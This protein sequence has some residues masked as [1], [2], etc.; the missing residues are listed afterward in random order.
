[1]IRSSHVPEVRMGQPAKPLKV[2]VIATVLN[3][4]ARVAELIDSLATQTRVPD[5][6]IIADGGST[7]GTTEKIR[8]A[9]EGRLKVTILNL[10]GSN[11]SEGRNAAV[12]TATGDLIA[13]T[14]AGVR[15]KRNWLELLIAPFEKRKGRLDVVSGFFESDPTTVFELAMG[16]TVLPT[17]DEINPARFLPSSR[18]VA[19]TKDA[20]RRAGG[21]PEW[22]DYCEDVVFDLALRRN[23]AVFGWAPEAVALFR[24]RPSLRS[25]WHQYFRY[26]RGDG[27]AGLWPLRHAVRYGSYA[28]ALAFLLGSRKRW[29]LLLPLAVGAL[30]HMQ[31]PYQRLLRSIRQL[32]PAEQAEAVAWVPI[33]R[34][35][36]D[37][38]KMAGYPVGI[39]WRLRHLRQK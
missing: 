15:L 29:Y 5:E 26:A 8:A 10:P 24:P 37:L 14:D 27:K 13:A 6:V 25:F 39:L 19:F 23:G 17:R 16:A 18:S 33:I 7:D 28:G 3:E 36:G 12:G 9:A 11:I 30:L 4:E 38:A 31:R 35:V 32:S 21:Y 20:W 2:S 1:M 22:L 34:V